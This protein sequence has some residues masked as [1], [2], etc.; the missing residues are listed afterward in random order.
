MNASAIPVYNAT[1][2]S[3]DWATPREFLANVVDGLGL[4][5]VALDIAAVARTAVAPLWLGPDHPDP[6]RRNAL[7]PATSWHV[8]GIGTRFLNCPYSR[9]CT[10]YDDGVWKGKASGRSKSLWCS[11]LKR[12]STTVMHWFRRAAVEGNRGRNPLLKLVPS[13]TDTD[14]WYRHVHGVAARVLFVDSRLWFL[15]ADLSEADMPA[16]FPS[17]VIEYAAAPVGCRWVT[18]FGTCDTEGRIVRAVGR[19]VG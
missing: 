2:G 5:P 4:P 1:N 15:N 16:P 19:R 7:D 11:T 17:V 8:D 18:Q 14:W 13:R 3:N 6:R 12:K 10:I 9:L